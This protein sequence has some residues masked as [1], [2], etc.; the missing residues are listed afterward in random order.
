LRK[1]ILYVLGEVEPRLDEMVGTLVGKIR[2]AYVA[3][4]AK[5]RTS[6]A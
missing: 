1:L 5:V 4:K 3:L 6:L 2:E